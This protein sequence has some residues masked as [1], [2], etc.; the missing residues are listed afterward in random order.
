M[1]GIYARDTSPIQYQD[2][3]LTIQEFTLQHYQHKIVLQVLFLKW[4]SYTWK[5]CLYIEPGPCSLVF[6]EAI[7]ALIQ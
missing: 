1:D 2:A 4:E 5:G 7:W 6:S 3:I